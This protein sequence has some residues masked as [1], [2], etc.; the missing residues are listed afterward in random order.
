[1][2]S[3]AESSRCVYFE[4]FTLDSRTGELRVNG[5]ISYLQDKPLKVLALL[6]EHPGQL[7]TRDE[8]MKRLWSADTFVDFD[9]SLNKAVNRLREALEDSTEHP[10]FIETLPRR[11]YRFIAPITLETY[12]EPVAIS[13]PAPELVPRV[14]EWPAVP[15]RTDDSISGLELVNAAS[16]RLPFL[17]RN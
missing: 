9:Q 1:M 13:R 7:V 4:E 8:L 16:P 17:R 12:R 10:R 6:L 11:G 14:L 5:T 3:P 15:D 2:G